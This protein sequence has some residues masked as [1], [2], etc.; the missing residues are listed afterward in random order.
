MHRIH[1][2]IENLSAPTKFVVSAAFIIGFFK[3]PVLPYTFKTDMKAESKAAIATV[4]A[5]GI[6]TPKAALADMFFGSDVSVATVNTIVDNKSEFVS[7]RKAYPA[8]LS[9]IQKHESTIR[10][11]ARENGVPEDVAIGIGL[12]ENGG[13]ETAK[14]PA[15]ALGVFQLMPGT[16]RNL[17]LKVTGKVDERR[18]PEKNIEAGMK[19][20]AMNYERFGDWGLSTWAYHAGE[21]N[22]AKAIKIYAKANDGINLPGISNFPAMRSYVERNNI[23]IH[24]LLSDP[25]VRAFTNKLNDDSVGY[26]YK[27]IATS[28]LF[29]EAK[30]NTKALVR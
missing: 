14:S 7:T 13:S 16:A 27:V 6:E 21:G 20:L 23:T 25:S 4:N 3:M 12:L 28:K 10:K 29:E 24:K 30:G 1:N 2:L 9:V 11:E 26:A 5:G 15:G 22:V 18:V 17:G 19:Y 8:S